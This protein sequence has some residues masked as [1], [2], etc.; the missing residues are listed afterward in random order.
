MND[1][2]IIVPMTPAHIAA[3]ARIEAECFAQPWSA[4]SLEEELN[5]PSAVFL[6]ALSG[7]EVAGYM[8][9]HHLGGCAYVCNVAV[10]RAFRRQGIAAKLVRA[11]TAAAR[12]AGMSEITLEVRHSN[13]AARALYEQSGFE[14]IGTRPRFY[15]DPT[16]DAEIYTLTFGG[17]SNL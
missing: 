1:D 15:S 3:I 4:R 17:G 14:W 5:V 10:A 8:G 6:T 11:Q 9:A 2:V 16:E 13:A 7:G 12:E